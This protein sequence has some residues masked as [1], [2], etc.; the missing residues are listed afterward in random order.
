LLIA[1]RLISATDSMPSRPIR[2]PS[3]PAILKALK[4]AG[5]EKKRASAIRVGIPMDKAFGV[6]VGTVRAIA[7]P[8]RGQHALAEPLW[9][10]GIHEARLLA[11]FVADPER[12][13]RSAI[14][15]WLDDVVSWDLCD[16]LCG[17]LASHRADATELIRRWIKSPKLYVKRA[18][19]ALIATLAVHG[20]DDDDL[21]A[22]LAGL[23]VEH[24]DDARPHV[25]QAASWALR[26]I[27]KRDAANRD[28]ALSAAAELVES[29]EP[30]KRWIGRDA[31]RELESLIKVRERGRL[32]TSKS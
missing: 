22:E 5:T 16:H 28:R 7:K 19:F 1:G 14:E 25:R 20:K 32:L 17:D 29:T 4:A 13:S 24:S 27:G 15:R 11:I 31:M 8:L 3:V 12:M 10:T 21:F 6:S 26:S 23:V 9:K 2:P 18:A 30:A